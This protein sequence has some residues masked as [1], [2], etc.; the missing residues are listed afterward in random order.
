MTTLY[1]SQIQ[2]VY[3]K[4][5][6]RLLKPIDLP[7]GAKVSITIHTA[8]SKESNLA[9]PFLPANHLDALLNLVSVGGDAL[10]DSEA[11]YD[12]DWA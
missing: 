1:S 9:T 12:E 3:E 8:G 4:G 7:E 10:A 5:R 11:V 2:A 6:L